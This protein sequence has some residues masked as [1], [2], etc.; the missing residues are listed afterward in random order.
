MCGAKEDYPCKLLAVRKLVGSKQRYV[1]TPVKTPV[2]KKK[3]LN[4]KKS[5][6]VF[7]PTWKRH[8][9]VLE[10]HYGNFILTCTAAKVIE[11]LPYNIASD[12]YF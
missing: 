3:S 4:L 2:R 6:S 12:Y 10:L 11:C 7:F 5:L 9:N 8:C 1:K